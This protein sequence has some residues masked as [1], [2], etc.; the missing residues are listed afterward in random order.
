MTTTPSWEKLLLSDKLG[1]KKPHKEGG[2]TPFNSDQDKI[3]FSGAFRR[4]AKKTQVHPLAKNDHIHN[5]L[6][7]SLE[8]SRVGRSLGLRVGEHIAR[9]HKLPEGLYPSDIGDIVQATCLAHDI[10]NPPFGHTGEEAI[11]DWFSNTTGQELI[12]DLNLAQQA[13]FI[14]FE[15]NA[16][17]FR[18]LCNS[19]YFVNEGGMRLTYATLASF[20]KYPWTS[21][22]RD[23]PKANKFGIFQSNLD[24]FNEIAEK[25]GL[26]KLAEDDHYVRHP[27]VHLMEVADDFCYGLLDLEDGMEM[28]LLSWDDYYD[29]VKIILPKEAKDRI[30]QKNKS[31]SVGRKAS[32]VRGDIISKCIESATDAFI[33]HENELIQGQKFSLIELCDSDVSSYVEN[34][35]KLAKERIFTHPE[36]VGLEIG[37]YGSLSTIL[38][39]MTAAAKEYVDHKV[40]GSKMSFKAQ[41]VIALLKEDALPTSTFTQCKNKPDALYNALMRVLDFVSGMTDNYAARITKQFKGLGP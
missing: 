37:A 26:I 12:A 25:V 1:G 20:I 6:T 31:L 24:H 33:E 2:R 41:R 5:R 7:H 35:K 22:L 19:E 36:K 17:G 28:G 18:V 15:G 13:D 14:E 8:V 16:Q 23:R 10:G 3:I 27:L 4:L 11:R 30:E 29:I 34:A 40:D 32:L 9:Q 39:V 38:E 21:A